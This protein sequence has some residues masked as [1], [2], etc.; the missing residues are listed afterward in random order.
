M[1]EHHE[2]GKQL[3]QIHLVSSLPVMPAV[4][5]LKIPFSRASAYS[6]PVRRTCLRFE[7]QKWRR[8]HYFW[9]VSLV[10]YSSI[11]TPSLKR[12]HGFLAL[13]QCFRLFLW[14][15]YV[16]FSHICVSPDW[17]IKLLIATIHNM[18]LFSWPNPTDRATSHY[19]VNCIINDD[20]HN[21]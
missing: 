11:Q 8:G 7:R 2:L 20:D 13:L 3:C 9:K 17:S 10:R 5:C 1:N 14:S 18:A 15:S 21:L 12:T 19:S 4:T 16:N 6:L